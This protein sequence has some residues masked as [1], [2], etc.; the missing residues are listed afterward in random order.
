MGVR[1]GWTS[2]GVM[3]AAQASRKYMSAL[4]L[5]K[6]L[7]SLGGT[8]PLNANGFVGRG[9]KTTAAHPLAVSD[10]GLIRSGSSSSWCNRSCLSP[11]LYKKSV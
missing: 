1:S 7:R 6:C 9:R 2:T 11:S 8:V 10:E 3:M 4:L 5:A